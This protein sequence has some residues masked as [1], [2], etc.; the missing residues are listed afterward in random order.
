M[1]S[2][3]KINRLI[4]KEASPV[5]YVLADPN[6]TQQIDSPWTENQKDVLLPVSDV[7]LNEGQL[8]DVF[9]YY[10]QDKSVHASMH[11]ALISMG[12]FKALNVVGLTDAGAFLDWGLPR[13]LFAP[14][15]HIH[16][17]VAMGVPAVVTLIHE[18]KQNRLYASAK[19][20]QFLL[21]APSKWDMTQS[22][23]LLIYA[24][25][26]LG[27]KVI[28]DNKYA[29]LLYKSDLFKTVHI[30]ETHR[31]YISRIRED[32]KIDVSLQRHDKAQRQSL[33]EQILSDLDAHGGL[34]TLT[35]KSSADEI[36]LRFNVSKG[37][38][39]KAIGQLYKD[40]KIVISPTHIKR[41]EET[42]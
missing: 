31:G 9:L 29:G 4:V 6:K 23:E 30:G 41:N 33:A 10:G 12:E 2:I 38:Y 34:S 22:V 37:A 20:E 27:Y 5:G 13:D 14:K 16:S 25:S 28:I 32:G 15:Q 40:K 11:T 42:K 26:P 18:P 3:G 39:K 19:I 17:E 36:Q 1:L 8:V 7:E 24:Q 35:D 21:D